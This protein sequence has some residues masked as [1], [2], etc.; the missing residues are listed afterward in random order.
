MNK[1][2]FLNKADISAINGRI[3]IEGC[4]L[5]SGYTKKGG[6]VRLGGELIA[7]GCKLRRDTEGGFYYGADLL[8]DYPTGQVWGCGDKEYFIQT[9]ETA[10]LDKKELL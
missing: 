3:E 9:I 8:T 1:N 2:L 6:W 4:A 5:T 7:E 10:I